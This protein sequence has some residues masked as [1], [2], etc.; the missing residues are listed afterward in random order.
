[1]GCSPKVSCPSRRAA[2]MCSRQQAWRPMPIVSE[3]KCA[4]QGQS[5]AL[6][7]P[8]YAQGLSS[9]SGDSKVMAYGY[10]KIYRYNHH[11]HPGFLLVLHL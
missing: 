11:S 3:W 6:L 4:W 1:M 5:R 9:T 8:G 7:R 2:A 10:W